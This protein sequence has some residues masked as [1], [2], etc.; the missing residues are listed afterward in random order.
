MLG[1]VREGTRRATAPIELD[2]TIPVVRRLK[3]GS[4][5]YD[6]YRVQARKMRSRSMADGLRR[7]ARFVRPLIAIAILVIAVWMLLSTR[8]TSLQ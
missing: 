4:I 5:D 2:D 3:D 6:F 1:D 8:G 7:L